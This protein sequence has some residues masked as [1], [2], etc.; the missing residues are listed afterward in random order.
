MSQTRFIIY[1]NYM[2][3]ASEKRICIISR[4]LKIVIHVAPISYENYFETTQ[5]SHKATSHTRGQTI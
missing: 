5:R 3:V 2:K 4:Q 1:Y